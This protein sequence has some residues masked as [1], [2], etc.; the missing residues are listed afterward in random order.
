MIDLRQAGFLDRRHDAIGIARS[1][2]AAVAGID[3]HRLPPGA[4]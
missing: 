4:T 1:G 3:Q 2:G